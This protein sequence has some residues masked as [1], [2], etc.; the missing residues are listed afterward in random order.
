MPGGKAVVDGVIAPPQYGAGNGHNRFQAGR[1]NQRKAGVTAQDIFKF[2]QEQAG[3]N[4]NNVGVRPTVDVVGTPNPF[5]FEKAKTLF[6]EVGNPNL[7]LR[8]KVVWQLINS[9]SHGGEVVTLTDVDLAHKSIK[10]RKFHAL[11]DA[12]NGGQSPSAKATW[13]KNFVE[14]FVIPA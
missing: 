8:G 1:L 6:D 13:G 3:G 9:D 4:P 12:L 2:V 7:A 10:A 14:L 5:P 11:L